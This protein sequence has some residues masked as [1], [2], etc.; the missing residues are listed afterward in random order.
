MN[1]RVVDEHGRQLAMGRNLAELKRALG[2]TDAAAAL[3]RLGAA[4][5]KRRATARW[6]FGDLPEIMEIRAGRADAGRLP[7]ARRRSATRCALQVFDS[8]EHARAVHR[9]G[10]RRLLALSFRERV[11]DLEKLRRRDNALNLQFAQLAEDVALKDEIVTAALERTFLAE[12]AADDAG[13]VRA[14]RRGRPQPLQPDRAG[15][16]CAPSA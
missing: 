8:P 2:A 13:G 4:C 16:R 12:A 9:A 1:F 3:R 15:A 11:R 10:L 14:Q 5:R 7:G 6:N